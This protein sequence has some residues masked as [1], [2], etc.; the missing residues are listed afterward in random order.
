M[1]SVNTATWL[2][3]IVDSSEDAIIGKTLDSVITSWNPAAERIFGYSAEEVIGRRMLV[4][5]PPERF[6]EERGIIDRIAR[7][8]RVE[9]FETVRLCKDGRRIEVSVTIS[10]IRDEEGRI[11]GASK[12]ARDI[13]QAKARERE[14][15]RLS[16]LYAALSQVNQSIVWTREKDALLQKICDVLVGFGGFEMAWI[17]RVQPGSQRLAPVA[18]AGDRLR[19][20]DGI[21]VY[22]DDR[23]EGRGLSGTAFREGRPVV[24]NDLLKEPSALPWREKAT[25]SHFRSA[26]AFPIRLGGVVCG[27]LSVYSNE[28]DFFLD[29]EVALLVEA[30]LDTSFGLD[31]LARDAA[32]EEAAAAVH[33]ERAF[34]AAVI[35]SLPGVLYIYDQ[36]G[37][38]LRWNRNFERVS[39][40]AADEIARMQP[41][42]F[43]GPTDKPRVDEKI[44]EVF[45]RGAASVEADLVSRD[46]R[47]TPYFWTG[48]AADLN[49]T[50][51]LVGVGIDVAAR[52]HAEDD[53]RVSDER[54]RALFDYAPDGIVI[55]DSH[56]E[57]IDVNAS[58]CKMLGYDRSEL[59]G[60]SS[61]DM[62]AP[63]EHSGIEP[64]IAMINSGNDHQREWSFRRKDGSLFPADVIATSMPDG[65]IL[66]MIRDITER[67]RSD[68]AVLHLND[69]LA[70]AEA[71]DQIKSAFLATM[72]HELRT[73]LNSIIGFTGTVL[74]G[75]AGP[76]T[77][78]QAKQLAMVKGSAGHL[79][80]LINDILDLSKIEA[81][82][83]DVRADHF[84]LRVSIERVTTS[85]RPLAERKNLPIT[86]TLAPGL[87]EIV[88]DRRRVEQILLNLLS[89]AIQFTEHGSVHLIAELVPGF[90]RLQVQDSG[91]GIQ[92]GDLTTLFRPFRQIDTGPSRK[93]GGTGL[94][95]AICR[96]L[97]A[98]LGGEISARSEWGVGSVFTVTLPLQPSEAP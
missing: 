70:R 8:E 22:V 67:R 82:Q 20:L 44:R 34:S 55:A 60:Q 89:N 6:D 81:G 61:V 79:L 62:V 58:F 46:G 97:A 37:R 10:P 29:R 33:R 68:A 30:A 32:R 73:P 16:R 76:V 64:A 65:R 42:D 56:G 69:T 23:P 43:F 26:A 40:Y 90:V 71:A 18:Q 74:R 91:I 87:G 14:I 94:G 83:L 11:V 63:A 12:I 19:Y 5:F 66:S 84:D 98:L 95:L 50:T 53:R 77:D 38:F 21:E 9:H 80:D 93:H 54:Y 85:V 4:L 92:A 35:A 75:L 25:T 96:R 15:A 31:N 7:G 1:T 36:T 41:L 48:V 72:S 39:G 17:G 49:G 88:S 78:E 3:A 59:V 52:K 51:C 2:A 57:Y 28:T 86:V 27:V 47:V 45:T 13:T 24:A